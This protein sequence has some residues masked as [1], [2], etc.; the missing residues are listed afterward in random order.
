MLA[1]D[2]EGPRPR[3]A[4]NSAARPARSPYPGLPARRL[5]TWSFSSLLGLKNG[6]LLGRHFDL[7]AGLRIAPGA[8]AALARAEAAEAADFDAVAALQRADDAFKNRFD[9]GFGFF[10]WKFV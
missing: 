3:R 2:G 9:D 7:G 4:F 10:A 1:A 8:A 5:L 6:M